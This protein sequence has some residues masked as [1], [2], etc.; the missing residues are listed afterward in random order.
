MTII[1]LCKRHDMSL[2]EAYRALASLQQKGLVT[3][4]TPGDLSTDIQLA[5]AAKTYIDTHIMEKQ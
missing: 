5:P 1:E 2:P 4:F 3:G